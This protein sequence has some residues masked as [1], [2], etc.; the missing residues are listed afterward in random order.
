MSKTQKRNVP[1]NIR[2]YPKQRDLIDY[3]CTLSGKNR[4]DFIL[5]ASCREAENIVLDQRLF[6][7]DEKAFNAFDDDLNKPAQNSDA[8]TRIMA[9]LTPWDK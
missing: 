6:I 1:I 2:A 5:E 3:A 7:L 8:I 9:K 4:T